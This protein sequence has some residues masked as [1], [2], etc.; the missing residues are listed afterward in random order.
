MSKGCDMGLFNLEGRQMRGEVTEVYKAMHTMDKSA[1]R[2]YL[3]LPKIV[4]SEVTHPISR[5]LNPR[6]MMTDERIS[7]PQCIIKL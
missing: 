5:K 4:K 1:R 3:S 2:S 6:R 7:P